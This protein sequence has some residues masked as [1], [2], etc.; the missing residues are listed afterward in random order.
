MGGWLKVIWNFLSEM[1]CH[2][3]CLGAYINVIST[4]RIIAIFSSVKNGNNYP[5]S[6]N[7]SILCLRF[8]VSM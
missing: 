7:G 4:N 3:G 6:S 1:N 8:L 2:C 5:R